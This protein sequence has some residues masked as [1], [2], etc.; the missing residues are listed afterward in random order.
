MKNLMTASCG[1]DCATCPAYLAWKNDDQALR[2]KTT[3][4]WKLAFG[5]DF[6][7]GMIACSGCRVTEGPKIGHCAECGFRTCSTKKGHSTCAA[8]ADYPCADLTVFFGQVPGTRERLE[9]LRK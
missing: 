7:P 9:A 1:L 3:E 2:E 4:E 8:C 6:S 5:Y